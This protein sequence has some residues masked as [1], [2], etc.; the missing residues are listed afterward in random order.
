MCFLFEGGR[1]KFCTQG[2]TWWQ[3]EDSRGVKP[4]NP[5]LASISL[6]V[7]RI[8]GSMDNPY[9]GILSFLM[10]TWTMHKISVF[11]RVMSVG[12]CQAGKHAGAAPFLWGKVWDILW[13]CVMLSAMLYTG[14]VIQVGVFFLACTWPS[15]F[16][17]LPLHAQV[18]ND[19]TITV[20]QV[21]QGLLTSATINRALLAV[22]FPSRD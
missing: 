15:V 1:E 13:D 22:H 20:V 19:P 2:R 7:Q 11:E 4:I 6:A 3:H 16:D 21:M 14:V 5:I 12:H 9:T 18:E 8:Y 10:L 17:F